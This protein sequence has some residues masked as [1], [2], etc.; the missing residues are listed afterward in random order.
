MS[1]PDEDLLTFRPLY[2]G[3]IVGVQDYR[4]L[5]CRGGPAAEEH[6]DRNTIV[7]LRRGAFCKHFGRRSVTAD[8]NQ[9]VFFARGSSYRISHPGDCGDSGT[10]FVLSTRVLIDIIRAL[11]PAVD[12]RPDRPFPFVTGPCEPGAFWRHR[13]LARRLEAAGTDPADPLATEVTALQLV[14]DVLEAAFERHGLPRQRRNGTDADHADRAEAAKGYLASRLADRVTL[15]DVARAVHTSPFHLA[16]VFRQRT[17]VPIHRYLN[18]L[19]LRAAIE[20]LSGGADDL[21][22]LALESGFSSHS[23]FTDAFRREFG[24]TPSDVRRELSRRT[25]RELSKNLEA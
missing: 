23:H 13:D 4:C 12:D 7:L 24:R 8:V 10:V 22:A 25:L 1:R 16:R 6:S 2:H 18:R 3:P 19:R 9:A 20:R 5:A 11:D 14:A 21:T 15:D 17:G